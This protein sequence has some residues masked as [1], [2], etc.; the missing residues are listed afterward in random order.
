[1][2]AHT[3][4]QTVLITHAAPTIATAAQWG[5]HHFAHGIAKAF[6]TAGWT[7]TVE[8]R[9]EWER[10]AEKA[11]HDQSSTQ[12][13]EI[14]PPN[15]GGLSEEPFDLHIHLRGLVRYHGPERARTSMIWLIS[16][17]ETVTIDEC[18]AV[19]LVGVASH[20]Y[21]QT[22]DRA[23]AGSETTAFPLLQATGF[24]TTLKTDNANALPP[25]PPTPILFIGNTRG[26]DRPTVST[27]QR[28]GF[29]LTVYGEGWEDRV[30]VEQIGGTYVPYPSTPRY[31]QNS[32]I[33]LNDH[34]PAMRQYGFVNNRI[35][36]VLASGGFVISD[37]VAGLEDLFGDTVPV[38]Q[39]PIELQLLVQRYLDS[40]DE[41]IS[42]MKK[43]QT[44][45]AAKHTF[46]HRVREIVERLPTAFSSQSTV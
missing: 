12:I 7:A 44:I 42:Q 1:M 17:P 20:Q 43:A 11:I 45:I 30:P 31:Y 26:Q 16:H 34:W 40:S 38:W 23:L 22:I 37:P 39:T 3:G 6:T 5:D 8:C 41:R 29:P 15:A 18:T 25:T 14:E 27:L 24:T 21:A 10:P 4:K 9:E 13:N 46:A 36:D 28:A 19:N 33:T 32:V 2:S 35:F